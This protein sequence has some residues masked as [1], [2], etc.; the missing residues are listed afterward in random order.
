[1]SKKPK[2]F[3]P[4]ARALL[5]RLWR[6]YVRQHWPWLAGA[7]V[8]MAIEGGSL[9]ALSYL[10]QPMFDRVFVAGDGSAIWWVGGGIM[11][12]FLMRAITGVLQRTVL[13]RVAQLTSTRMQVDLLGHM[14]T[15]DTRFF[16]DNAPGALI[17]R[18]QGDTAAVQNV[19]QVLIQGLGRDIVALV[20]LFVVALS[21]DAG[22]TLAA[23]IGVPLLIAPSIVLQR[24]V[25]K[26]TR[27]MR[28]TSFQRATRL[29]E[30]FH[31]INAIKLNGMESYQVGRFDALVSDIVRVQ[32]KTA[33]GRAML[34]GLI[35]IV[36]GV[37]FFGVLVLGGQDII[38]GEKTVGEFM[39]F[40]TA[41]ALAF[42]PLRRI[43]A[44]AGVTQVAAAS[45]DNLYTIFDMR[46]SITSGGHAVADAQPPA[47]GLENVSFSYDDNQVLHGTTLHADAGRTTALVGASGAGKSTIFNLLTRLI[48]P[49]AGRVTIDDRDVKTFNLGALRGLFSVVTQDALLFDETIREN[50]LLGRTDVSEARLRE[51]VEAAH[52]ADFADALPKGIETRAGPRG[53]SL[54]GGQRQRVA[55]ARALLRD[56]PILL[57]DEATSALDAQS[58]ALIQEALDRLSRGRTTIVI[59]HRL[60]TIRGADRIVV[61]DEGRVVDQGTHEELIERG[62]L[63]AQLYRLQFSEDGGSDE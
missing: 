41:M 25:R 10:L 60:A 28:A 33:A 35:D 50:I 5:G 62:G 24:Y 32:I 30:I 36:T 26:K 43:G 9:G 34:P 19:W 38:S 3:S 14:M 11:L 44:V 16:S 12:L 61:M 29:D 37:G 20:S 13:T 63:Y 45:L 54:S 21:I 46:P 39:S 51:V 15:L 40:F 7:F 2:P 48:E 59:A 31:G 49:E 17:E 27:A 1:M 18:V 55:I 6:D 53:S 22:W 57:L 4:N 47:I 23:L 58:E 56:T 52:V 8:L 42:Q